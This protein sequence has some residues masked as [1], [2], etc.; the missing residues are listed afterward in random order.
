MDKFEAYVW[1]LLSFDAGNHSVAADLAALEGELGSNR[2]N[3]AKRKARDLEQTVSRAVVSH[4]C[5]W[6]GAFDPVPTPPPPD[7][8]RFCR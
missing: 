8:Q 5:D 1:L 3:D 2:V 7:I 4:G 6:T